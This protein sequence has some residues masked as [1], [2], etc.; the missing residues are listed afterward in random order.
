MGKAFELIGEGKIYEKVLSIFGQIEICEEVINTFENHPNFYYIN[1]TIKPYHSKIVSVE[2]PSYLFSNHCKEIAYRL[3]KVHNGMTKKLIY[4]LMKV[5]TKAE[6]C[7]LGKDATLVSRL[8]YEV[9][10]NLLYMFRQILDEE[11]INDPTLED[12]K[13]TKHEYFLDLMYDVYSDEERAKI[14]WELVKK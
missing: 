8:T 2:Y 6:M 9:K 14:V 7:I 1:K 5:P 13:G 3:S 11:N 10:Q 4:D 12:V